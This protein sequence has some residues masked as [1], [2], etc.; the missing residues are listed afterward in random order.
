MALIG[1][2][3]C[4][5][6]FLQLTLPPL[7]PILKD[8]LHVSYAALGLVMTLFFAASGV[9]QTVSGFLVDRI[10]ARRVLVGGLTLF[11]GAIASAGLV[12]SFWALLL[13]AILAGLG[14][15][16]FHPSD[17]AV[18]NTVID[19]RRVGRAFSVHSISGNIG[20]VVA[21]AFVGAITAAVSWRAALV[22]AGG[23]A[24]GMAAVTTAFGRDLDTRSDPAAR[25]LA[26]RGLS[27][28]VR[29]LLVAP[30]LIA[31]AYFTLL[32]TAWVGLQT[33]GVPTIVA[34]YG[35]PL[36]LAAGALTGFLLGNSLGTLGGGFVADHTSRHDLVAAAGLLLAGAVT[37]AMATGGIPVGVLPVLMAAAGC[38]LGLTGPS[39]DMLVR[40]ATPPGASGKV[41]GF[42]YSGLD[43]GSSATPLLFGWMLDHG[44][45]RGVF[46]VTAALMVLTTVTVLQV[47][48][49]TVPLA[50]GA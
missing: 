22:A 23:I 17:Y 2:G 41:Y 29:L 8:E 36:A 15:S 10:G 45:P 38:C 31:F 18:F 19:R 21:P 30:I 49:R 46:L 48:R 35:A 24:V 39:R 34:L 32:A 40:S 12:T 13:V 3:H 14:N 43:L 1:S 20:W 50:V 4:V 9:G 5:S 44:E 37:V 28:D 11:G 7:F 47:R 25:P 42:V 26:S 6:H 27:G 16:V 33:F